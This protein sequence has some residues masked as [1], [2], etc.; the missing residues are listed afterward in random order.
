M[1]NAR[2]L[3]T[4]NGSTQN[5]TVSFPFISRSHVG[6]SMNL[7]T[8][9]TP[10]QYTWVS[11][12]TILFTTAPPTGAAVIVYRETPRDVR[13][14]DF[15]NGSVLT[16][17]ELDLAHLQHFYTTQEI[18]DEY[19]SILTGATE[20]IASGAGI[21]SVG[22]TELIDSMVQEV[23]ASS[24]LAS[25]MSA[26]NDIDTNAQNVLDIDIRMVD[27]EAYVDSIADIDGTELVTF[28][29][30]EQTA[31][32]AADVAV[33]Q[34]IA[35]LGARN[36]GTTAF[37]L[38]TATVKLDSNG[39]DT[40]A[41]RLSALS[42][43]DSNNA[44]A[45]ISEQGTRITQDTAI[46]LSVTNLTTTVGTHT[47]SIS[48]QASS[49]SGLEAKYVV[50]VNVNGYVAG[51]GLAITAN[52]ATPTSEFI[53]LADKFAVVNPAAGSPL[54]PF[55]VT[56][57]VCYMQNVVI[58]GALITDASI[59]NA[60][61]AGLA[62]GKITAGDITVAIGI[63]SG[64]LQ[65]SSTGKVYSGKTTYADSTAG[66]WLG[67]DSGTPKFHIGNSTKSMTWDGSALTV[68]GEIISTSNISANTIAVPSV[69][70]FSDT[71]ITAGGSE[72]TVGTTS[73]ITVGDST[74]GNAIATV[75]A[76]CDSGSETDAGVE[77]RLYTAINGVSTWTQ[78]K[79]QQIGIRTSSGDTYF[80][81]PT[82]MAH[83]TSG[84]TSVA[85]SLRAAT[86]IMTGAG[87]HKTVTIR[88]AYISVLGAKR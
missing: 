74:A 51:Y 16:E 62:A 25:L 38:N 47:S 68:T 29:L 18:I 4:G 8:Q 84:V 33:V 87:A 20:R 79:I 81:I 46:A 55:I 7:I 15:T 80:K 77:L 30:N 28:I 75:H 49:I 11:D 34:D 17:A 63:T 21:I 59:S 56:G 70:T 48:T 35:L 40:I 9:L 10:L 58:G 27:L 64:Y 57:G 19:E 66:W 65:I 36:V 88:N 72:Y 37:I 60:K 71:A 5:F 45:I 86:F 85:Y 42:V 69:S 14:V 50:K 44:A 24:L 78:Q 12:S 3:Y 53:V 73:F 2:A 83:A 41:T 52:D 23:L 6:V 39:G 67:S 13:L 43:S 1:P 82:S 61:I 54:V 22:G 76:T 31:R 26:T 32:I